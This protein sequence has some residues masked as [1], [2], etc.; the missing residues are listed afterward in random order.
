VSA[1]KDVSSA[2]VFDDAKYSSTDPRENPAGTHTIGCIEPLKIIR[3]LTTDAS[4]EANASG[5][6]LKNQLE[7]T[8]QAVNATMV[9]KKV[10][11]TQAID[12]A[13]ALLDNLKTQVEDSMAKGSTTLL[14][15]AKALDDDPNIMSGVS[16]AAFNWIYL[17]VLLMV[18]GFIFI[19]LNSHAH[20]VIAGQVHSNPH[21]EGDILDVGH[22]G[23]CGARM[24]ALSWCCIFFFGAVASGLGTAFY[25]ISK[26]YGDV[27][28]AIEILPLKLGTLMEGDRTGSSS[29]QNASNGMNVTNILT[30]CWADGSIYDA[31]DLETL[32]PIDS[33]EMFAGF[34]GVPSDGSLGNDSTVALNE[35]AAEIQNMQHCPA[36]RTV[37]LAKID[38]VHEKTD[39][40]E[41]E[42]AT[43][44]QTLDT[45]Q[46]TSVARLEGQMDLV[47]CV[48][49]GFIRSVW[50][51]TF[52]VV[53]RQA[54][55]AIV[56]FAESMVAIGV[57]AFFVGMLQLVILRRW[58]GLGPIKAHD[59]GDDGFQL[60]MT[61]GLESKCGCLSHHRRKVVPSYAVQKVDQ[62]TT[63][64]YT[65]EVSEGNNTTQPH[66]SDLI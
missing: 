56:I 11:I 54:H 37:L 36:A 46:N 8:G 42:L 55:Q 33:S 25:P 49:C 7:K 12:D 31:M 47:K 29:Q 43:Y 66:G 14:G 22:I 64:D 58:A 32:I 63:S 45:I 16:F 44:Q 2:A 53:C 1:Y 38:V 52:D 15:Q 59:H 5:V 13:A 60:A 17:C 26:V 30:T 10:T 48:K 62:N 28:T 34:G 20:N 23:A 27:C 41:M 9:D 57:F 35:L 51:E 65:V 4:N 19:L 24:G 50:E 40:L 6:D 21:M 3:E 18:V 39:D 61:H